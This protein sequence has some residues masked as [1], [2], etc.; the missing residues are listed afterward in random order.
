MDL[1]R[2]RENNYRLGYGWQ[3]D[4]W[5][6][7]HKCQDKGQYTSGWHML[8]PEHSRNWPYILAGT[9][10]GTRWTQPSKNKQHDHWLPDT[11][12][13][14]HTVKA[15]KG[16]S[17]WVELTREKGNV[18]STR[19]TDRKRNQFGNRKKLQEVFK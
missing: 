17:V 18:Q 12:C 19:N 16:W 1:Q 7:L 5:H 15:D 9:T 14:G 4:I 2:I 10:A 13:W 3:L 11:D 8:G 6:W